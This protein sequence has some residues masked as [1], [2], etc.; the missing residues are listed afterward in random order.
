MIYL[1][2][3]IQ[4]CP[5][6]KY[7]EIHYPPYVN[8]MQPNSVDII[9][10]S[11]YTHCTNCKS[12]SR[13]THEYTASKYGATSVRVCFLRSSKCDLF[14]AHR[15]LYEFGN[16]RRTEISPWYSMHDISH[17]WHGWLIL[18]NRR[19]TDTWGLKV[20][21]FAFTRSHIGLNGLVKRYFKCLDN[22][23]NYVGK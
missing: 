13:Q 12:D 23:G 2:T 10:M 1:W 14:L 8:E 19:T 6:S 17:G 20:R 3:Y 9:C 4:S 7:S 21:S 16:I 18:Q 15:W 5:E 22:G 11:F